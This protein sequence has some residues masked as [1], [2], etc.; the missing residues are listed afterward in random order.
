M[1]IGRGF[2]VRQLVF[3]V[4]F[5]LPAVGWAAYGD[6]SSYLGSPYAGD[7]GNARDAYLDFAE[8]I[9]FNG[10]DMVIADTYNNVIRSING[11]SI[12]GT[13]AGSGSYGDQDGAA[14]TAEFA[15]PKGVA[16]DGSGTIYV[17][18]TYNHKIKKITNGSVSTLVSEG[19]SSPE[20]IAVR[21]STLYIADTGNNAIKAVSTSG[22][23]VITITSSVSSPKKLTSTSSGQHLYVAAGGSYQV[24]RVAT[25]NGA[26]EVI[27]G[28]GSA[29]Y[30]N[31]QGT[32]AQF[33]NVVGVA[34][35]E[36]R[37][38]L[39]VTDGDGYTDFV[40]EI[41][42]ASNTVSTLATDEVMSTINYPKGIAAL[43][44]YVYVANSGIGTIQKFNKD[45]GAT[46]AVVDWVAGKNRF[47]N[48]FGAQGASLLGRPND[49]VFTPDGQ[50]MYIAENNF[51]RKVNMSDGSTS[52][53]IGSV[54]DAYREEQGD[55][56]RFSSLASITINS[57]GTTLYV[58]D[59]WNNRIRGIDLSSNTSFLVSGGGLT[60]CS[61]SC[62]G[63]VE[64]VKDAARFN[65]PTGIAISPDNT[66]LYVADTANNRVRKVRI[67]DGQTSLLAGSGVAGHADG[68]GS[69]AKF[70]SPFGVTLD[71]AGQY[72]YVADR[73]NHRLRRIDVSTSEVA[74]VAGNGNNGYRDAIGTTAVLS[75]PEYVKI[76]VDGNL[77]FSEVG[78]QLV[79]FMDI[80]SRSV[81]TVSGNLSRGFYNGDRTSSRFNNPKGL[82]PDT[83]NSKLYVADNWNDVIRQV[84]ITGTPPYSNPAPQP[85]SVSPRDRYKKATSSSQILSLNING[86]NFEHGASAMLGSYG[87]VKTYVNASNK[88]TVEI[89]F[90]Q[91]PPAYY[92]VKV[93][94]M[95]GQKG[96]C[97]KCFIVLNADGSLPPDIQVEES[98]VDFDAYDVSQRGGYHVYSGNVIG[99]ALSPDEIVTGTEEGFGP[100]VSIFDGNGNVVARFFAYAPHLRSG[101]RVA[102]CDLDR[103]GTEEIVTAPGKGGRPHIRIFSGQGKPKIH[104]GFFALD[105]KF[106]GGAN[107]ACGDVNA[108]G[109]AEIIVAAAQGGGPHV[110]VHNYK[111]ETIASFMAY[112]TSF[113]G[114]IRLATADVNND[115][116]YEIITGPENGAPHVQMFNTTEDSVKRL[117][118]GF[119]AFHRNFGG[120]LS[121]TGG[122]VNG[123][124]REEIVVSQRT[125]GQAWVKV[126]SGQDQSIMKTFLAYSPGFEG[127]A[128]VAAGD[129]DGDGKDEV[130]TM[131]G[132]GGSPQVRVFDVD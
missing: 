110:T 87:A 79:K 39:Y 112:G 8:D 132:S 46:D 29:G 129:T 84:S 35:D 93:T 100:Q 80:S 24:V 78:S 76:G 15:L 97:S 105:G 118:P 21:G 31:G 3:L 54:V 22:G 96:T 125:Q 62:N 73:E 42:L 28:S 124:G 86:S 50:S 123:D 2:I 90:G 89:P 131:P 127:G 111:G 53:V 82:L 9:A 120:G 88:L 13:V 116:R 130:M 101:V 43:G 68:V 107:I 108:D 115:N 40:R 36:G 52:F 81:R 66:Y 58:A 77:Y 34:L 75:Y 69:A 5:L 32:N 95:D 63:Y 26:V 1:T 30:A 23:S 104:P 4:V 121:L 60:D 37:N 113:R 41:D 45:N 14:G 99:G 92:D 20:G 64:G 25:G 128:V 83:A 12:V 27:A 119:Y 102:T 114:G 106:Q 71:S 48:E 57:T 85:T 72:L 117:N 11:S 33:R 67:S 47:G 17:A 56:A 109:R 19:L 91:M 74:T 18:D 61:N 122:D 10:N 65:N 49:M 16:A 103:D 51:V 94:N 126:Y 44:D 98:Q 38:A 59:R 6:T 55:R 70:N 7:G